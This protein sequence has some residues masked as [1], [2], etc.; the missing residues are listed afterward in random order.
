MRNTRNTAWNLRWMI[1]ASCRS[2]GTRSS[3][4]RRPIKRGPMKHWSFSPKRRRLT[5]SFKTSF[6]LQVRT[7]RHSETIIAACVRSLSPSTRNAS[8][9]ANVASPTKR[10]LPWTFVRSKTRRSK[11]NV[12]LKILNRSPRNSK[13]L[14]D[15]IT[16]RY[17]IMIASKRT[18]TNK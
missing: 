3:K 11:Q 16:T 5:T 15:P 18:T 17:P 13:R 4:Q 12:L 1:C 8:C 9:C 14:N 2:V 10:N 6:K 7:S